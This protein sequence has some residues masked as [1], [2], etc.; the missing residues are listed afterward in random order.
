LRDPTTAA[1]AGRIAGQRHLG[2]VETMLRLEREYGINLAKKLG[3]YEA[4]QSATTY[5]GM[6]TL[7]HQYRTPL[8]QML[9]Q[10]TLGAQFKKDFYS[11]PYVALARGLDGQ[12]YLVN[13]NTGLIGAN[14]KHSKAASFEDLYTRIYSALEKM[15]YDELQSFIDAN[16]HLISDDLKKQFDAALRNIKT[17]HVGRGSTSSSHDSEELYKGTQYSATLSGVTGGGHDKSTT[18]TKKTG[19]ADGSDIDKKQVFKSPTNLDMQGSVQIYA[20]QKQ[21]TGYGNVDIAD[22][23]RI[24][25]LTA[26]IALDITKNV[27]KQDSKTIESSLQKLFRTQK[28][29]EEAV[30]A[31][32]QYKEVETLENTLSINTLPIL[33]QRIADKY[34]SHLS[35]VG[36]DN[37]YSMTV[38][39]LIEDIYS[40]NIEQYKKEL[41]EIQNELKLQGPQGA[42]FKNAV[43]NQIDKLRGEIVQKQQE[44]PI[45]PPPFRN[46]NRDLDQ[47]RK[48]VA[49]HLGP[50][51]PPYTQDWVNKKLDLLFWSIPYTHPYPQNSPSPRGPVKR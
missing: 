35:D 6:E 12:W 7:S 25:D 49:T 18:I 22:I 14:I 26:A 48:F 39:R 31:A 42:E 29:F 36:L 40:G 37:R 15:S 44:I 21:T 27:L 17:R 32:Q 38:R 9:L 8:E 5:I 50:Y 46:L 10:I 3:E 30:K 2:S 16:R 11:D 33:I 47:I 13:V 43:Q 23:R 41:E 20:G 34:Y 1:A 45:V 19:G 24:S 51:L 4:L 28:D